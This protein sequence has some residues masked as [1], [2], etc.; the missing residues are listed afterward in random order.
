MVMYISE[1]GE[2]AAVQWTLVPFKS[3]L[4]QIP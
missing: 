2:P 1:K 4:L 3:K